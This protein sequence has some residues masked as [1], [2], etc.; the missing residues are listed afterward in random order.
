[1]N[2]SPNYEQWLRIRMIP[3]YFWTLD[4]PEPHYSEKLDLDPHYSLNSTALEAKNRAVDVHNGIHGS[5]MK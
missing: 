4:D 2:S 5:A 3:H 1:M